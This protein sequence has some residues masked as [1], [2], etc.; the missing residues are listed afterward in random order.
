MGAFS[1]DPTPL[2][3]KVWR[4]CPP[5]YPAILARM[6]DASGKERLKLFVRAATIGSDGSGEVFLDDMDG[7]RVII[8]LA[9]DVV[10][11]P[12]NWSGND[13]M[14]SSSALDI[15]VEAETADKAGE[16]LVTVFA[17]GHTET[18]EYPI[19]AA[20]NMLVTIPRAVALAE[21]SWKQV[22]SNHSIGQGRQAK[23][24]EEEEELKNKVA[25]L[26]ARRFSNDYRRAF[27]H[28]DDNGDGKVARPELK[29]LLSDAGVGNMFTRNAWVSGIISALDKDYDGCIS[30][31]EFEA[32][33]KRP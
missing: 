4:F 22:T 27:N 5:D 26:V 11:R 17:G 16:K 24:D 28:Y 21:S 18:A 29:A 10:D 2:G 12:E 3:Q 8:V 33:F 9:D 30:W 31:A 13:F 7:V 25:G 6:A 14:L 32:V 15:R 20:E 19:N 1:G 23:R